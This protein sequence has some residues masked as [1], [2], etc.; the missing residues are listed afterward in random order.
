MD[1]ANLKIT[2]VTLNLLKNKDWSN[3]KL[4]EVKNKS[5]VKNFDK[6]VK[7]KKSL[8]KFINQYFDYR[9]LL[10]SKKIEISNN[11]DMIFEIL[12][13]R[14][15]LL[16]I[17]RKQILSIYK[18]FQNKP[19]NLLFLLPAL[20]DSIIYMVS[21]TNIS[22]KGLLGR[23]KIKGI[24]IVY[25]ASFFVWIKDDTDSLEKTMTSLDNN[26]NQADKILQFLS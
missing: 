24:F 11:K 1:K 25:I 4:V 13:M 8:L 17:Y 21:L 5:N 2:E 9:L 15:D 19:K 18:S 7:D 12:M 22:D 26:L 6:I 16:Q 20:L 23:A 14:F 3:L 10:D